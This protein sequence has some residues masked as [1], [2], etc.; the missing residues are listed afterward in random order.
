MRCP[1]YKTEKMEDISAAVAAGAADHQ[2]L[3]LKFSP[4][5]LEPSDYKAPSPPTEEHS[6]RLSLPGAEASQDKE[7]STSGFH[8][9]TFEDSGYLTL[10][11]S[12]VEDHSE[13]TAVAR[14]GK[15]ASRQNSP[16]KSQRR[17]SAH[18][19]AASPTE[20]CQRKEGSPSTVPLLR[21]HE[22]VCEEL[23]KDFRINKRYGYF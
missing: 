23:A 17:T 16:R 5:K 7:N 18:Q 20:G 9:R 13:V 2:L 12:Q 11:N 19:P 1:S 4:V 3:N 15:P 8:D 14:Q 10:H 6:E 21:F 22:A